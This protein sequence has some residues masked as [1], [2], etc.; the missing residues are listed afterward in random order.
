MEIEATI[1]Y[2]DVEGVEDL[3]K[4][5]YDKNNEK[6]KQTWHLTTKDTNVKDPQK[7]KVTTPKN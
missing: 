7:W 2:I 3:G 5:A 1:S 4:N 6:Y